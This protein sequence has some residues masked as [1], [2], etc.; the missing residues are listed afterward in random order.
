VHSW[1]AIGEVRALVY[2]YLARGRTV[3]PAVASTPPEPPAAEF[4]GFAS[5]RYA[6]WAFLDRAI[7][8][9]RTDGTCLRPLF[10]DAHA[11]V[12]AG[13]GGYKLWFESGSSIRFTHNAEGLPIM[14]LHGTYNEAQTFWPA[15][16]RA[17]AIAVAWWLLAIAPLWL[18]AGIAF[19]LVRGVRMRS[20]DLA[21][22]PALA[23]LCVRAWQYLF[24]EAGRLQVGGEKHAVTIGICV[25]SCLFAIAACASVITALRWMIRRDRPS[26]ASRLV[27]TLTALA[28]AA[29]ASWGAANS[30]I[31][32]RS[33]LW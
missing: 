16:L 32:F 27:P 2:A 13:D 19:S 21:L 31:G 30:M 4:Y 17:D 25:V 8:G 33:W 5:P 12:P 28:A 23:G 11:I 14:L 29:L 1:R 10:G 7:A 15:R 6:L 22:W 24:F 18:A 26:L 9:M 20:V 3:A